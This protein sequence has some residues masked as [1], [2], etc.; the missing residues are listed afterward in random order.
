MR[1]LLYAGALI[2]VGSIYLMTFERLWIHVTV[3]AALAG[4]VSH[5]LYLISDLDQAFAGD[6]QV[7]KGPFIRARKAFDR[8]AHQAEAIAA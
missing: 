1:I 7:A 6:W 3:T 4:A 5:I 2:L 8:D